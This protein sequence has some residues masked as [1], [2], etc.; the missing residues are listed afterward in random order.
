ME[1]GGWRMEEDGGG[2]R[3]GDEKE[4]IPGDHPL[5]TATKNAREQETRPRN[6]SEKDP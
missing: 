2:G 6:E 1:D 4:S 3:C 5:T